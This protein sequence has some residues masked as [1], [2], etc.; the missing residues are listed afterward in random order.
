MKEITKE[1]TKIEKYTVYQ[2]VD[3]TEFSQK[4][5]CVKYETSALGVLRGKIKKF[6]VCEQKDAWTFM[7]GYDDHQVIAIK[8]LIESDI[9]TILQ[10][11]YLEYPYLLED[12][13]KAERERFEEVIIEAWKNDDVILFG[14]NCE[15]E[16]YFI[17]S[18]RN[19]I[20]NLSSLAQK[21]SSSK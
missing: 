6:V 3:G 17:N 11:Y 12:S 9:D 10:W 13:R 8:P 5:E 7:G 19:I 2:A 20:N 15:K 4:E 16:Y 18:C 1:R 21:D 14:I